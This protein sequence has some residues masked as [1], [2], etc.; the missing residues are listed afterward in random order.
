MPEDLPLISAETRGNALV[1]TL[2]VTSFDSNNSTDIQ[3]A[4]EQAA[5]ETP[6]GPV[7]IDLAEVEH[8]SSLGL[9]VLIYL[10]THFLQDNRRFGV[11]AVR[12]EAAEVIRVARLDRLFEV[13]PSVADFLLRLRERR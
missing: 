1:V 7:A 13:C 2:H 8:L 12:R 3:A 9:G 4:I 10:H 6:S 11:C 5:Q